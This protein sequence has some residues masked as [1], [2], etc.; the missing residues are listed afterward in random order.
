MKKT[1]LFEKHV[2]LNAK[3]VDFGGFNM[4]IQYSGISYEHINVRNNVGI[5]DVSHMGEFFV[6]GKEAL[7]FLNHVCSNNIEKI[8]INKA[9]YNCF[10]NE[11]GG[12]IDDLIVY[13]CNENEYMLVVNASNIDKD[14]NWLNRYIK[15]YDCS[16]INESE[17]IGL[18]SVQGP[19]SLQ[20]IND[21]F[22]KDFTLIKKFNFK[23]IEYKK[24]KVV[25]SNTGYTG[26]PGY[27]I[28]LDNNIIVEI[29][30][31]LLNHGKKYDLC[32]VGLGARDTLRIEMGY[33]LY[34]NE[35]N[36][37]ITPHEADLMW[38]TDMNKDFVGKKSLE[39][40]IENSKKKL[41]GFKMIDRGI[42]RK[43]Y[44]VF[45]SNN[46]LIG[47]VTSGTFSPSNKLGVGMALIDFENFK[48]NEIFIE[49]RN[50]LIKGLI[51]KLP[52]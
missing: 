51:Q 49:Q 35:I 14:W 27:E 6:S 23:T 45:D 26:S 19:K 47:K 13:R 36:D 52:I 12:I 38:I 40:S 17:N 21:I 11:N 3:M 43:D 31:L 16:I 1:S 48:S 37:D 10:T 20:L 15:K 18:I 22:N 9:Q 29:W 2:E 32:P 41:V 25:I 50:K 4:P 46:N 30:D 7:Q 28:Y 39:K 5:F 34:G 42:P 24:Y 8:E 44:H 33:C